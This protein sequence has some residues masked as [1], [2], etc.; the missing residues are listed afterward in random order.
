MLKNATTKNI[1]C[2]QYLLYDYVTSTFYSHL[3]ANIHL[4]SWVF[5]FMNLISQT[6]KLGLWSL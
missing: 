6:E 4:C 5:F 2:S 3:R 1:R